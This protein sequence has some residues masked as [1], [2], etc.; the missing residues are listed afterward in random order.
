MRDFNIASAEDG[1]NRVAQNLHSSGEL[2]LSEIVDWRPPEGLRNII[3]GIGCLMEKLGSEL[4]AGSASAPMIICGSNIAASPLLE[5][6]R[7]A[8]GMPLYVWSG[9]LPHTPIE[10]VDAGLEAARETGADALIAL[11]GSS[12]SDC[13]KAIAVLL[14]SNGRSARELNPIDWADMSAPTLEDGQR[15]L[16]LLIAPTTL[17]AAEFQTFFGMR[18]VQASRKEPYS[19]R[20]LVRRT[21]FLDGAVA[22]YT[23]RSIWIETAIKLLDDMLYRYCTAENDPPLDAVLEHCIATVFADL[24]VSVNTGDAAPRQR[25]FRAMWLSNNRMPTTRQ[26][27][28]KPWLSMVARHSIGGATGLAHGLGS[29]VSLEKSLRFHAEATGARQ[30]QLARRLGFQESLVDA[31]HQLLVSAQ[32]PTQLAPLGAPRSSIEQILTNMRFESPALGDKDQLSAV[33]E[34]FW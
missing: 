27:Q 2:G 12:T 29:C 21:I 19:E 32:A 14:A 24:P 7:K 15:P 25:L 5:L 20:N 8:A 17:S 28:R 11:G 18:D 26:V 9:S 23:P 34:S 10:A 33:V 13:A 31:V 3:S 22:A 1:N 16:P 30:S 6:T 4:K